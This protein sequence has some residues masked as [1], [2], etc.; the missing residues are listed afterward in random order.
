MSISGI[1]GGFSPLSALFAT[2]RGENDPLIEVSQ[3]NV[4]AETAEKVKKTAEE[5]FLDYARMSVAERIRA[6]MLEEE[7]LDEEKLAKLDAEMRKKIEE[8]I[9]E[10]IE[11]KMRQET[12][13]TSGTMVNL[14]A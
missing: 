9:R 7:G 8:K 1:G 6:Q 10:A 5:N 11:E 14:T 3:G 4:P 12:G 13:V 2:Q